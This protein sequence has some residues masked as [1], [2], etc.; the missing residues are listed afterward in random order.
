MDLRLSAWAS[1]FLAIITIP[2]A[3]LKAYYREFG[4]LQSLMAISTLLFGIAFILLLFGWYSLS[5]KVWVKKVIMTYLVFGMLTLLAIF[6]EI[7]VTKIDKRISSIAALILLGIMI[8]FALSLLT[9][10]KLGKSIVIITILYLLSA[11]FFLFNLFALI[12]PLITS[13]I[14][15]ITGILI[16]KNTPEFA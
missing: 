12:S 5:K 2:N 15:L 3:I 11:I 9:M 4:K 10:R 16:F 13:A 6:Y 1:I 14:Y 7:F 8:V